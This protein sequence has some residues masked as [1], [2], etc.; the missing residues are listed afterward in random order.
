MKPLWKTPL[1][2]FHTLWCLGVAVGASAATFVV[3]NTLDSGPGSF[4]QALT[5][6]SLN[7]GV[8]AITFSN[9]SGQ[10]NLLSTTLGDTVITGPG[11][12]RLTIATPRVV[13]NSAMT[14][15]ISGVRITT[16][17]PSF[18]VGIYGGIISN[19]GTLFLR[20]CEVVSANSIVA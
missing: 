14:T 20:D 17:G 10:I 18:G 12:R 1:A 7:P 16:G 8:D 2:I 4:N 3:T 9:V 5:D 11:A 19:G 15:T 13:I 6:A